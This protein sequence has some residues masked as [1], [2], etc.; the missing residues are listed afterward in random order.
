MFNNE[1]VSK[2]LVSVIITTFNRAHVLKNA[3]DSVLNQVYSHKEIIVI[4]DGSLD[5]TK[6]L[7]TSYLDKIIPIFKPNTGKSHSRNMGLHIAKGTIIATLDSDDVWRKDYLEKII[8]YLA[9]Q[10]LDIVFAACSAHGFKFKKYT[11]GQYHV[12]RYEKIRKLVLN[13]CPA[14]TSGVVM[15]RDILG[16]GWNNA[17]MEFEDWHLQIEC[18][19]KNKDCRVGYVSE[20]LWEKREDFEVR[21]KLKTTLQNKRRTQDTLTLLDHLKEDFTKNEYKVVKQNLLKDTI[22]LLFVSIKNGEDKKQIWNYLNFI[23]SKP[24]FLISTILSILKKK[25]R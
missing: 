1:Q 7:L 17:S 25:I 10:N 16:N 22:R 14:P 6:L 4:D 5:D 15:R 9:Y 11:T 3:I 13:N 8:N 2:P 19:V 21:N 23:M 18:V 24:I 12:F 20:I